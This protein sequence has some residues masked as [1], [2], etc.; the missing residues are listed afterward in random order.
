[1]EKQKKGARLGE[2][3]IVKGCMICQEEQILL[4]TRDQRQ[5]LPEKDSILPQVCEKCS[6]KYLVEGILLIN[7]NNGRLIVIKEEAFKKIFSDTDM[8]KALKMRICFTD[9]ELLDKLEG[10]KK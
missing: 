8:D 9:D 1:M 5:P 6:K 10:R 2:V 4:A 7:P 3:T